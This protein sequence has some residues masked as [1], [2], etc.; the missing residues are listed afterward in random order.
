MKTGEVLE[1]TAL[2][3]QRNESKE[4]CIKVNADGKDTLVVLDG[5]SKMEVR[6][7]NPHFTEIVFD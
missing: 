2:D 6:V 1:C 5:I 4:E 3:T 7:E